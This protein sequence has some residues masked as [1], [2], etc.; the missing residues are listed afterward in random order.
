MA[1]G[2]GRDRKLCWNGCWS[3][4]CPHSLQTLGFYAGPGMWEQLGWFSGFPAPA[5]GIPQLPPGTAAEQNFCPLRENKAQIL[6]QTRKEHPRN[7]EFP[8]IL[9][10]PGGI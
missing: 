7:P 2:E 10:Q 6:L 8:E 9:L 5:S 3:P 1:R 4:G